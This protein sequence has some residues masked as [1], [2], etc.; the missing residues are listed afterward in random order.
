[1][2]SS[3]SWLTTRTLLLGLV[4]IP[5]SLIAAEPTVDLSGYRGRAA[6]PSGETALASSWNG[7]SG[8]VRPDV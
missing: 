3:R 5:S 4:V 7:R 2:I 6:L 8:E 1:M